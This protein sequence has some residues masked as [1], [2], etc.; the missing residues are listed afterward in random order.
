MLDL[1]EITQSVTQEIAQE[2]LKMSESA[3][4]SE[5]EENGKVEVFE[6]GFKLIYTEELTVYVNF[7]TGPHAKA[8]LSDKPKSVQDEARQFK[9]ERD[10]NLP[11]KPFIYPAILWALDEYPKRVE[12]EVLNAWNVLRF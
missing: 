5:V 11:T 7:G 1:Q 12:R 4:P 8:Y 2:C 10:G 6:G 9:K 3:K